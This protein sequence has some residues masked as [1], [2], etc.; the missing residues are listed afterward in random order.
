MIGEGPPFEIH[1]VYGTIIKD[2]VVDEQYVIDLDGF[3]TDFG[4]RVNGLWKKAQRIKVFKKRLA[5]ES[6]RREDH[7]SIR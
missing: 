3:Y 5:E 4:S 6:R 1:P 2:T 7:G